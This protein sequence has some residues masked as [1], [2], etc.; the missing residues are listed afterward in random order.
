MSS[1]DPGYGARMRQRRR[2]ESKQVSFFLK[3][4]VENDEWAL[5]PGSHPTLEAARAAG[6][7]LAKGTDDCYA[8]W[9]Q[10]LQYGERH[11]TE[12]ELVQ[13]WDRGLVLSGDEFK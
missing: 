11:L 7:R 9:R 1:Y 12:I 10:V 6:E 13:D 8:V 3:R 5:V 2:F 4:Q